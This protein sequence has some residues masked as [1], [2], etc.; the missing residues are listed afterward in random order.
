MSAYYYTNLQLPSLI[1]QCSRFLFVVLSREWWM[2]WSGTYSGV[3]EQPAK[4]AE[5]IGNGLRGQEA[6][7]CLNKCVRGAW[8]KARNNNHSTCY[9]AFSRSL[10][11]TYVQN[12]SASRALFVKSDAKKER[13]GLSQQRS[14]L[15]GSECW[16]A[17]I[18]L[19]STRVFP[20][21][22]KLNEIDVQIAF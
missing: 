13:S 17:S 7:P 11:T 16:P 15:C 3:T 18:F 12:I 8:K 4:V 5:K 19:F 6:G 10:A 14:L 20:S 9:M 21:C 1:S 2:N 22:R